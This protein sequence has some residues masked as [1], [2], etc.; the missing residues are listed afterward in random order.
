[1]DPLAFSGLSLRCPRLHN[2]GRFRVR[3][4]KGLEDDP[5]KLPGAGTGAREDF[6]RQE[7]FD[8]DGIDHAG[9]WNLV[10]L[11]HLDKAGLLNYLSLACPRAADARHGQYY[12]HERLP[13]AAEL[14]SGGEGA[15]ELPPDLDIA[16]DLR[17]TE[18]GDDE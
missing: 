5:W 12:W 11:W 10:L 2:P 9:S 6:F 16:I 4:W 3:I 8:M 18:E 15:P 13:E 1:M 7:G 17:D 14:I